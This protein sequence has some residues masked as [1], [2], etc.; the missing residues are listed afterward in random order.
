MAQGKNLSTPWKG[1]LPGHNIH[2]QPEDI[3]EWQYVF[4]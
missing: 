3:P 2:N 1:L 4:V